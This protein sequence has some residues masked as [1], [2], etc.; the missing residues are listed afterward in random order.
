VLQ[1]INGLFLQSLA[2]SKANP[3]IA[4]AVGLWGLSAVTFFLRDVPSSVIDFIKYQCMTRL[5]LNSQDLI[6]HEFLEWLSINK[7]HGFVRTINLNSGY[8]G[9]G[10]NRWSYDSKAPVS[11][12]YGRTFFFHKGRLFFVRRVKDTATQTDQVKETIVVEVLGRSHAALKNILNEIKEAKEKETETKY[13]RVYAYEDKHWIYRCRNFKRNPETVVIEESVERELYRGI[14]NF[15]ASKNW[16]ARNGV[17]YRLGILLSGPPGT[18]KTSLIK[19]ICAKYNRN[20]YTLSLSSLGDSSFAAAMGSLPE[21]S[22]IAIEDIDGFG[23]NIHR[24]VEQKDKIGIN[25]TMSGLLNGIDGAASAEDRILILTTNH[26]HKLDPAL[27]RDGRF[28]IKLVIGNMTRSSIKKYLSK[29]YTDF[30]TS[31]EL[32]D[33]ICPATAQRLVFENQ[34]DYR[35]VVDKLIGQPPTHLVACK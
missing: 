24:E 6:Y 31:I 21:N 28:D 22:V 23:L 2:F 12:G 32:P 13:T 9:V 8:H 29:M 15:L 5:D 4:S 16:Y 19:A 11:L 34:N 26:V 10:Y 25:L 35:V 27:L 30:D 1:E 33:D 20:L 17:P 18:G 14:D 7:I 3:I